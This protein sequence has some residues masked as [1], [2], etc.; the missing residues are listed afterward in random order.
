MDDEGFSIC[1]EL[2]FGVGV[3]F[4]ADTGGAE[5]S[6]TEI[7]GELGAECGSMGATVGFKF[8]ECGLDPKI[9]GK[10]GPF[11]FTPDA[12]LAYKLDVD[13]PVEVLVEGTKCK[14][15]GKLAGRV[16]GGTK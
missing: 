8:D 12:D 11:E 2:G 3:D 16:C 7:V 10:L 4:G 9:K 6:G 5:D 14:L 13:S 15:G 1:G